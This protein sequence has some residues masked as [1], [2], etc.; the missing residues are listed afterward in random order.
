MLQHKRERPKLD[1]HPTCEPF[2]K[3]MRNPIGQPILL[4]AYQFF[5]QI[6]RF[7]QNFLITVV[8]GVPQI[9]NRLF[10]TQREPQ[11]VSL[12]YRSAF[13]EGYGSRLTSD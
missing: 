13:E 8:C 11:T 12:V 5:I 9:G 10:V 4:S 1:Y 7:R 3:L 6:F 2:T